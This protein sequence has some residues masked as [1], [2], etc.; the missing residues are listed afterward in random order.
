MPELLT[1]GHSNH[2]AQRF[3]E[4]LSAAE[5]EVVADVRSWPRSRYAEWA[6]QERLPDLLHDRGCGYVY[7]G[8]ALGGRPGDRECYDAAGH[9]LYGRVARRP[10]FRD[11]L[12]RLHAGTSTYRVVTM[13]SEEDPTDC[14]RR[15][16]IAKVL[17][18][19]G[20]EVSHIRGD[21]RIES[22]RGIAPNAANLFDDED[23]W[24][25]ST[26]SVSRRRPLST[27]SNA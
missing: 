13:C 15:L 8:H 27:S 6:N 4:L 16:L 19:S 24:W 11:G 25:R 17:M 10:L 14:H 26:R 1:I 7:L 9:V 21:G 20:F 12:D 5:V 18:E 3:A 23:L 2:T 22:E